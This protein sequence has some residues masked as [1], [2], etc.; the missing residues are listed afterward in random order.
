MLESAGYEVYDLGRDVPLQKFIDKA[1]EVQADV[2]AM[3]TLMST[4]MP[5]MKRVIEML[6]EEGIRKDY[7]VIIGGAPLS[8]AYANKIQADGYSPNAVE[9]VKLVDRLL[10]S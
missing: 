4:T 5:G 10:E 1:K 3:S 2:I 8:P 9:A 7:K 6:E